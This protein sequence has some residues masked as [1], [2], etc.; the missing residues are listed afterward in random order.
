MSTSSKKGRNKNTLNNLSSSGTGKNTALLGLPTNTNSSLESLQNPQNKTNKSL[1]ELIKENEEMEIKLSK[2]NS[3]IDKEKNLLMQETSELNNDITDRGFEISCLS[4]ENKNL[5]TQ[6]KDIKTSLD[7]KMKISKIF[8]V[9]M[10]ELAKKEK[11]LKKLIE[12]KDREIELAKKSCDISKKDCKRIIN[13][14]KNNG[15][16]KEKILN[17]ELENLNK[18]KADLETNNF[19]L[20]K[21]INNHKLCPR[22][23]TNLV[24]KLNM[25]NNSYEFEIKKTNM[26]E[27]NMANLEEKKEKIKKEIKEKEEFNANNRS[28]SYCTKIRKNVL[29]HMEKKNSE[30][31][32]LSPRGRVHISEICKNIGDQNIK[33]SGNIKQINNSDY[34]SKHKSLFTDNEQVQ[35]AAII[36]P[37]Y[38]NE[39]KERFELVETERCNLVN[40]LKN[41]K[42]KFNGASDN[43]QLKLNFAQLKKREQKMHWVDMNANLSKK[44]NDIT[45]LKSE[46]KKINRQYNN[47]DKLLKMKNNENQRL[48]MYINNIQNKENNNDD[49]NNYN[50][51]SQ[52]KSVST[53]KISSDNLQKQNNIKLFYKN[54]KNIY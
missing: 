26:L 9:K 16:G 24:S 3:E 34:K 22:I 28:I 8:F 52:D 41:N 11:H 19:N 12:I 18:L 47:W 32:M 10:Q 15:E 31:K 7:N 43:I 33:T 6:L 46:I 50:Y 48:N 44:N 25:L 40:K 20:R 1:S 4:S 29:K 5:M 49:N 37:S 14:A 51:N 36:P 54:K 45:K 39:F 27:T 53:N 42:N 38:L 35:L 21:I 13:I 30:Q 23:K 2:I 17:D